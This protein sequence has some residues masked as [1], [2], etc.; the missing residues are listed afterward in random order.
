M[1][2]EFD[3][4]VVVV[5]SGVSGSLVAH[6]LAKAGKQVILLEAGPRT[7]R[8]QIVEQFR[9][10]ANKNDPNGPY[11]DTHYAP[12]STSAGYLTETGG[13]PNHPSYVRLVGGTTWHWAGATYRFLPND[14]RMK[15]LY[16]VSRDWPIGYDDLESW[17]GL[18]EHA[19]G[20]SGPDDADQSATGRSGTYPPRSTPY[21][22][23]AAPLPYMH[24][25]AAEIL[26]AGG[27]RV[28][29]EPT[30]RNSKPYDGRP[31][32]QGNNS[33]TPVCP[34]GALYNGSVHAYKAEQSGAQLLTEAVVYRIECD[35]RGRIVAVRYKKPDGSDHRLTARIFVLAAYS[36]ET[37]KLLLMSATHEFPNGLA[38]SSDMV[39]R[40]LTCQPECHQGF[41][42]KEALWPGRGPVH[43]QT[44]FTSR[45]GEF[46]KERSGAKYV[47]TNNAPNA[48]IAANLLKQGVIGPK[49]DEMIR[50][51]ASRYIELSTQHEYPPDPNN[52]VTLSRTRKDALGLPTP[53]IH[54]NRDHPYFLAGAEQTRKEYEK[55]AALFGA[56]PYSP[57]HW[58]HPH[59]QG[60]TIMGADPRD[61]VVDAHGRTHDHP[62]LYIVGPS[63]MT[64]TGTVNPTLTAA[65]LALRTA[66]TVL[67]EL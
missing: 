64:T 1:S 41:L 36:I 62:N 31:A 20:V 50:D 13:T 55:I 6:S 15:S 45:D 65:A 14:F 53:E 57:L 61:S 56:T 47:V 63:V 9:N 35:S 67:R 38:N 2:S 42:G 60:T 3:A 19:L 34:I 7:P 40:N 51:Q 43:P 29:N 10:S 39:G 48:I 44:F 58:V 59:T 30:A 37:P 22:M 66:D 32:C 33:C 11:P 24:Q 17:Y 46:R 16:G 52:R 12:K 5:G 27:Y 8:W 54:F 28:L 49:L 23:K 4:D 26:T 21:P 25:R 18:A